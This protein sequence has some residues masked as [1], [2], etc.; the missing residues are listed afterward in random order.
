MLSLWN[1]FIC[2]MTKKIVRKLPVK[3]HQYRHTKFGMHDTKWTTFWN[4][5]LPT[6][7]NKPK[8]SNE[9]AKVQNLSRC[10][11]HCKN[12]FYLVNR[13]LTPYRLGPFYIA[14]VTCAI[15]DLVI[16][17]IYSSMLK[18]RDNNAIKMKNHIYKNCWEQ[19]KIGMDA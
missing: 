18:S 11:T 17:V 19:H 7:W 4:G 8:E 9:Y 14:H 5:F 10:H 12:T 16:H 1:R 3:F 15:V 13:P 2:L 6:I